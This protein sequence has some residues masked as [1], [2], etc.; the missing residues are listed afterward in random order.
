[1]FH[2]GNI[3]QAEIATEALNFSRH[4]LVVCS[5]LVSLHLLPSFRVHVTL[6]AVVLLLFVL[7]LAM[8]IVVWIKLGRDVVKSGSV[9]EPLM[10]RPQ[11]LFLAFLLHPEPVVIL[12]LG[13]IKSE[14]IIQTKAPSSSSHAQAST[15]FPCFS[16]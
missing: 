16:A 7:E 12:H 3:N 6:L 4:L 11:L 13:R 1:M 10:L 15:S 9:K 2:A 5:L 14:H 8:V